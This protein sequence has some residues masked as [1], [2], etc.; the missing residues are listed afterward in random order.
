MGL[1]PWIDGTVDPP[2]SEQHC[3]AKIHWKSVQISEFVRISEVKPNIL[4]TAMPNF[5]HMIKRSHTTWITNLYYTVHCIVIII[6]IDVAHCQSLIPQHL[7]MKFLFLLTWLL[8]TLSSID[9][10]ILFCFLPV[11]LL[12]TLCAIWN[13]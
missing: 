11:S 12:I 10:V 2:L 3:M 1:I 7:L 4:D 8:F 5:L 6:L 9:R 13:I